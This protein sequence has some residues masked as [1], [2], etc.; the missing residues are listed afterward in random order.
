MALGFAKLETERRLLSKF[1]VKGKISVKVLTCVTKLN[2]TCNKSCSNLLTTNL[3]LGRLQNPSPSFYFEE[4]PFFVSIFCLQANAK[5]VF[6]FLQ[7][8]LTS[9]WNECSEVQWT[10]ANALILCIK[11][12]LVSD[13][14]IKLN[15]T[16]YIIIWRGMHASLCFESSLRDSL[17]VVLLHDDLNVSWYTFL[18]PSYMSQCHSL[19]TWIRYY[20]IV[21]SF[22][23][24]FT[25]SW[26]TYCTITFCI[27]PDF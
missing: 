4:F 27:V 13:K 20:D 7:K 22:S 12:I 2:L 15:S 9:W 17:A 21:F 14:R 3:I 1:L 19:F 11:V 25:D 8:S 6:A 23:L 18:F 10:F 5:C 24:I 16:N 26:F